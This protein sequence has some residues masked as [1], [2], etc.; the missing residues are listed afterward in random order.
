MGNLSAQRIARR[1]LLQSAFVH[2]LSIHDTPDAIN[3]SN[4]S[5]EKV[6]VGELLH[7]L[8]IQCFDDLLIVVENPCWSGFPRDCFSNE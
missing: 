2:S 4:R 5:L 1:S 3:S 7:F 8:N 6:Y